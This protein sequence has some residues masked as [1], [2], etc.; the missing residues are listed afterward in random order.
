MSYI[1]TYTTP[2]IS[3]TVSKS[4]TPSSQRNL[5]INNTEHLT[6]LDVPPQNTYITNVYKAINALNFL[7][8]LTSKTKKYLEKEMGFCMD[9]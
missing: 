7:K 2:H 6:A 3:L 5:L 4:S 9:L 1:V 8:D